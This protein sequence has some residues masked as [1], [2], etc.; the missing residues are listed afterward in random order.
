MRARILFVSTCRKRTSGLDHIGIRCWIL[1]IYL[2]SHVLEIRNPET[3]T[4]KRKMELGP[5]CGLGAF[6]PPT[7]R[8]VNPSFPSVQRGQPQC[9]S[10]DMTGRFHLW[11]LLF[12]VDCP[13]FSPQLMVTDTRPSLGPPLF[14]EVFYALGSKVFFLLARLCCFISQVVCFWNA[15]RF[16][17]RFANSNSPPATQLTYF[18]RPQ[19]ILLDSFPNFFSFDLRSSL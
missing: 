5:P 6:R 15:P 9:A 17:T 8:H 11:P 16:G 18:N 2:G 19:P 1:L 3:E 14:V 7:P 10:G 13:F 12:D 4:Q